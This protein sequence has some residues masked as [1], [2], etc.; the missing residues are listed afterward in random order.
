[1]SEVLPRDILVRVGGRTLQRYGVL[2]VAGSSRGPVEL[3][4]TFT[5]AGHVRR[6]RDK[7]GIGR[8][9]AAGNIALEYPAVLAGLTDAFGYDYMGPLLEGARPQLC[10]DPENFGAWSVAGTPVL[11]SGQ[12]DPFGG[13]A[14]YLVEDND[15]AAF[16]HLTSAGDIAF[17]DGERCAAL[18]VKQGSAS[19]SWVR[20]RGGATDRHR[21]LITWTNG[22]PVL[23]TSAGAGT[24][25]PVEPWANGWYRI[26]F[27]AAGVLA[28]DT[29]VLEFGPGTFAAS[30][31]GTGYFFGANAW[32]APFPSSYQGPGDGT[33]AADVLSV[34]LNF[35]PQDLTLLARVAR[36]AHVDVGPTDVTAFC[37]IAALG[38]LDNSTPSFFLNFENDERQ[39]QLILNTPTTDAE[40]FGVAIP[41]GAEIAVCAQLRDPTVGGMIRMDT[42][43]G[44]TAEAGPA[45]AVAS[46]GAQVLRI[47][48]LGSAG[49]EL[50]GVLLDV[51]V[52]RGLRSRA[53]MVAVE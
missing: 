45:T 42:G 38:W 40:V 41:A 36:P 39:L 47:G 2:A 9:A 21:V 26:A 5:R 29:N 15:A 30:G 4:E 3:V 20:L 14:A 10:P 46:W 1:M 33:A 27:S 16:E 37:H 51:I 11:T 8:K 24:R 50:Y 31:T 34:P 12:A 19:T 22:V 32:D 13:T 49:T 28:A 17:T 6:F 7:N 23:S 25:F 52:A 18:F 48:G 53:E 35:G 43:S 44:F